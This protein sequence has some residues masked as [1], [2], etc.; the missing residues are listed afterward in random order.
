[1]VGL[2]SAVKPL[3]GTVYGDA[4]VYTLASKKWSLIHDA[5]DGEAV[6]PAPRS[7][8]GAA[9]ATVC[10]DGE[11]IEGIGWDVTCVMCVMGVTCVM[12]VVCFFFRFISLSY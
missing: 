5:A 1:M 4:W 12:C 10:V 11:L 3:T 2:T 6:V 7:G 8:H 9:R